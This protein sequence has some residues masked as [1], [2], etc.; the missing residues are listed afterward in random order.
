MIITASLLSTQTAI[1]FVAVNSGASLDGAYERTFTHNNRFY[2]NNHNHRI[3][4][5]IMYR[6][7]VPLIALGLFSMLAGYA[8]GRK[9]APVRKISEHYGQEVV[10][11]RN[12]G[13]VWDAKTR[14]A[15]IKEI[16]HIKDTETAINIWG[17]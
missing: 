14:A 11:K 17:E 10:I 12:D 13:I 7:L 16:F 2:Y 6:I 5:G 4:G 15:T 9:D 3:L 8:Q 1:R